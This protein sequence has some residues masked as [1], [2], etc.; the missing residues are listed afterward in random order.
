MFVFMTSVVA[1]L[2]V[3]VIFEDVEED[4]VELE[5]Y[6]LGRVDVVEPMTHTSVTQ[7]QVTHE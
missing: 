1:L 7:G 3:S 5:A 6:P 4:V 2:H